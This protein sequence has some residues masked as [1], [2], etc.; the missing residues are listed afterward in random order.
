MISIFSEEQNAAFVD[1]VTAQDFSATEVWIGANDLASEVC[2]ANLC[3][4]VCMC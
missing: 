3:V 2:V 1:F 4:C